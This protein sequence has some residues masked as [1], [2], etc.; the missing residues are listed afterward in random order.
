MK[1]NFRDEENRI[2]EI[3]YLSIHALILSQ[4]LCMHFDID[5][6]ILITH[7]INK[8]FEKHLT[9]FEMTL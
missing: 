6:P 9:N 4:T 2:L 7:M 8:Y 3:Q 1:Y 5:F